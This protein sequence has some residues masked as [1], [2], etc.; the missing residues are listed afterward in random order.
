[1]YPFVPLDDFI[2]QGAVG[3]TF[4]SLKLGLVL[5]VGSR[6]E[7]LLTHEAR[8]YQKLGSCPWIP[9]FHGLYSADSMDVLVLEDCGEPLSPSMWT[10][11][12]K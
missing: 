8:L 10:E 7:G 4:R 9:Q 6:E 12:R 11:R 5:K 1:M 3:E 2:G